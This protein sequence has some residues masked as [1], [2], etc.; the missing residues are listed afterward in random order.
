MPAASCGSVRERRATSVIGPFPL[1]RHLSKDMGTAR[2]LATHPHP[3][4]RRADAYC[5]PEQAEQVYRR[6][7]VPEQL[8]WLDASRHIDDDP[9]KIAPR[10]GLAGRG[11]VRRPV[12]ADST[13][14]RFR[15]GRGAD[16]L[17]PRTQRA[18]RSPTDSAQQSLLPGLGVVVVVVAV[19]FPSL[20]GSG[21][22]RPIRR[23]APGRPGRLRCRP[24]RSCRTR[25]SRCRRSARTSG[26][27]SRLAGVGAS[28]RAHL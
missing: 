19:A 11:P 21:C 16:L 3:H 22:P 12:V 10:A 20:T 6:A 9:R 28:M 26:S 27:P 14:M 13:I 2:L 17:A 1:V 25:T 24:W 4:R 15:D 23:T 5:S 7:S 18:R 8:V